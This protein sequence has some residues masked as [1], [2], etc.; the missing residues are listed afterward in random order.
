[1]SDEEVGHMKVTNLTEHEDGSATVEFDMD[2]TTA[3]L[4]QE[5]GLKLL[6]YCG[7]T[8]TDLDF[9]FDSILGKED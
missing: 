7:A 9:V 5:L 3:A 4:A 2:D 1:M 8:G 6:I